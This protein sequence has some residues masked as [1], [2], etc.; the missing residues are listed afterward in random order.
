MSDESCNPLLDKVRALCLSFPGTSERISHG[1]PT[2]F[3]NEKKSFVQYH[4]NH[5]G[6]GKIALWCAAPSGVQS[7]LVEAE[8][9]IYYI[10]AYVGHLG[11]IGVRLDRQAEWE[12]IAGAIGGAYMAR[13][14]KKLQALVAGRSFNA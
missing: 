14:P 2:F 12:D 11:W 3:V 9:D 4:N 5:H 7:L 8:P 6:D 13:A 10:P 1:A